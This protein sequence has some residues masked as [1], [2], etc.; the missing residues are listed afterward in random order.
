MVL[1]KHIFFR[2]L[3]WYYVTVVYEDTSYGVM[4]YTELQRSA[5]RNDICIATAEKV[6]RCAFVKMFFF[7]V[8]VFV[9]GGAC[10]SSLFC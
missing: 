9:V 10:F 6:D 5:K 7:C 8:R 4:G 2:K 3:K 1:T